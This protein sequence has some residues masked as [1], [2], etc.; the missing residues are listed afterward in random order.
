MNILN[1]IEEIANSITIRELTLPL[2]PTM[3]LEQVDLVCSS[4]KKAIN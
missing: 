2:Y 3:T 4:L 1:L